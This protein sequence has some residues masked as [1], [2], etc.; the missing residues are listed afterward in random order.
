MTVAAIF[1]SNLRG[2]CD[3]YSKKTNTRLHKGPCSIRGILYMKLGI[4]LEM[5]LEMRLEMK[6]EKRC[7]TKRSFGV[8]RIFLNPWMPKIDSGR[9]NLI[10]LTQRKGRHISHWLTREEVEKMSK[11][12]SQMTI[13]DAK[14]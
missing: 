11:Q 5:K 12:A 10:R 14:F 9:S 13:C 1:G 2:R 6:W 3:K 7:G 4:R 8:S